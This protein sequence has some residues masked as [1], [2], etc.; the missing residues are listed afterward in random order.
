MS[1]CI[2]CPILILY[3]TSLIEDTLANTIFTIFNKRTNKGGSIDEEKKL[4]LTC[5]LTRSIYARPS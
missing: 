5:F 2:L 1:I 3:N 4:E